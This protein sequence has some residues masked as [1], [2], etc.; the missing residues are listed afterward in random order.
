MVGPHNRFRPSR[1]RVEGHPAREALDA[2]IGGHGTGEG[3]LQLP[4]LA[5][6]DG[7]LVVGRED[8]GRVGVDLVEMSHVG[9]ARF[10]VR[11]Q[12]EA[13]GVGE[14]AGTA[15]KKAR[16]MQGHKQGP[17]VVARAAADEVALGAGDAPGIEMPALSRRYDVQMADDADLRRGFAREIGHPAIPV[18][19][20]GTG[21]EAGTQVEP[22]LQGASGPLAEGGAGPAVAGS[23]TLWM[24]TRESRSVTI[25]SQWASR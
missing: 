1:H 22:R 20:F 6:A 11:S 2:G 21:A 10:L 14:A 9:H 19:V 5:V 8:E 17:L 24:R 13:E 15:E 18:E 23:S 16:R 3:P 12:N 25:S 7:E 4:L